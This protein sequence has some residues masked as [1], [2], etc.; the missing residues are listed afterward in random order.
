MLKIKLTKPCWTCGKPVSVNF[1][2]YVNQAEQYR[3]YYERSTEEILRERANKYGIYDL[4][5]GE[6]KNFNARRMFC[7]KCEEKYFSELE[8]KREEYAKLRKTLMLERAV[9]TLEK[10]ELDIYQMKDIIDQMQDFVIESPEKFDSSHEMIAAIILVD[11]GIKATIGYKIGKYRADFYIPSEKIVLEIDGSL[12]KNNLFRD[13]K[14][15][16]DIRDILGKDWEVVRIGTEYLESNAKMLVEAM[17]GIRDEKK[18][19]RKQHYGALPEWYSRRDSARKKTYRPKT[20]D[21][22]FEI[23]FQSD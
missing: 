15:D 13:N 10:Q 6:K 17:R 2:G 5:D 22:L 1:D 7:E 19:I 23:D 8:K 16:I 21:E 12:H 4:E 11:N 9:R 18:K 3:S 20:D 14:R